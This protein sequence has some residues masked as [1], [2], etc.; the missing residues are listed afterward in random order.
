MKSTIFRYDLNE[1]RLNIRADIFG[2]PPIADLLDV[3]DESGK[4]VYE[5]LQ[6]DTI[7]DIERA[8]VASVYPGEFES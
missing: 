4:D 5:H 3:Q 6:P 1:V 7:E 2:N 8:A